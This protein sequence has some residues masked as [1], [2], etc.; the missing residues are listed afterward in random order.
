MTRPR[1]SRSALG[2][3]VAA[4]M[5]SLGACSSDG[6]DDKVTGGAP[7]AAE[8]RTGADAAAAEAPELEAPAEAASELVVTDE[9]EGCGAEIPADAVAYVTVNYVGKAH[10]NGEVFDSS[11]DRGQPASFPVGAGQLIQGWDQGLVGMKE[12][13][14]RILLVPGPLAYGPKGRAPAIGPND[15]LVFA[16]DL[17]SIDG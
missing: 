14:R 17:V 6:S 2:A 11:F 1:R 8:C 12:G 15:T 9:I 10:S 5:L 13:G 4:A 16:I 3:L 7:K